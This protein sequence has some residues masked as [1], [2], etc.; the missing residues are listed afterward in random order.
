MYSESKVIILR[1]IGLFQTGTSLHF[2][3]QTLPLIQQNQPTYANIL[4]PL[5]CLLVLHKPVT[6]YEGRQP[7]PDTLLLAC[8]LLL[9]PH[10]VCSY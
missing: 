10:P 6:A 1:S 8:L 4:L 7:D 5:L 3:C 9:Q 2:A